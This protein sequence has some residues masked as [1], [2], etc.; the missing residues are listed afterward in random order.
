MPSNLCL[1]QE[2]HALLLKVCFLFLLFFYLFGHLTMILIM[3]TLYIQTSFLVSLI[4]NA[5][6]IFDQDM[7]K[8]TKFSLQL[9]SAREVVFITLHLVKESFWRS[10]STGISYRTIAVLELPLVQIIIDTSYYSARVAREVY[11]KR[12]SN[13]KLRKHTLDIKYQVFLLRLVTSFWSAFI[14]HH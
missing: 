7:G 12:V 2:L 5:R 6:L 4:W 9:V 8:I 14:D 1:Q 3:H 13:K 11:C 10:Y